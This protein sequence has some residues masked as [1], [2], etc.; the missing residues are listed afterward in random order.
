MKRP[1]KK[2]TKDY[3][4]LETITGAVKDAVEIQINGNLRVMK[5][6]ILDIK[7]HLSAQDKTLK[8]L[9]DKIEPIDKTR[10]NFEW[11]GGFGKSV[12]LVVLLITALLGAILYLKDFFTGKS[13]LPTAPKIT[14]SS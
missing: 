7:E 9:N 5:K 10:K 1:I 3:I 8:E 11:L 2:T 4:I 6:D 14:I 12:I 13:V